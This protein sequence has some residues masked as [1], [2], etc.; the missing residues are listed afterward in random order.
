MELIEKYIRL[1]QQIQKLQEELK[2]V[3]EE[4]LQQIDDAVEYGDYKIVKVVKYVPKL[5]QDVDLL[6]IQ[7]KYPDIVELKIN[8]Y[9]A[10]KNW[11][12]DILDI[13]ETQYLQLKKKKKW[14]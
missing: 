2:Q 6:E 14:E 3:Q 1:K 12:D 5:K 13:Q 4:L 8:P 9:K 7:E 10:L 11:Y